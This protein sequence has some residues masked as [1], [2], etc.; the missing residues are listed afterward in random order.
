MVV[1]LPHVAKIQPCVAR[2][3]SHVPEQFVDLLDQLKEGWE[4]NVDTIRSFLSNP[5]CSLAGGLDLGKFDLGSLGLSLP[6]LAPLLSS[7]SCGNMDFGFECRSPPSVPAT[8]GDAVHGNVTCDACNV[9]PIVGPRYNCTVCRDFDL[10]AKCEA[11]P[12]SHPA[13]HPMLKIRQPANIP[14]VHDGVA[15]D[16]C[17]QSPI[18]GIRFKCKVCPDF[19]LCAA[20]EAKNVHPADHPLVK[21]KVPKVRCGRGEG[22][23]WG[24]GHG[25][26]GMHHG[27]MGPMHG[28]FR[29]LMKQRRGG[30]GEHSRGERHRW[31]ARG[32]VGDVVKQVQQALNVQPVD[33]FFGPRTEQA[34][35][36]YQTSKG[37]QVDGVVGRMTWASLFPSEVVADSTP[38][39]KLDVVDTLMEVLV[40]MGFQDVELNSRLLQKHNGDLEQIVAEIVATSK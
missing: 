38:P 14:V 34:V 39:P 20:C 33:G 17:Q 4:V 30:W 8:S 5:M 40:N 36:D 32:A 6:A 15:C 2:V 10:C 7:F 27:P 31:L 9:H 12:G 24:E 26:R 11:T 22:H 25:M 1:L 13:E 3:L 28:F 18:A 19:D 23:R 21:F 16:G 37:L 29:E 35:R